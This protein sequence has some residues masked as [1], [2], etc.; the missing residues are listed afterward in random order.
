MKKVILF[1]PFWQ[2]EGHVGNNR[3]NRFLKWLIEENYHVIIICAGSVDNQQKMNW[4]ELITIR[5][6]MNLFNQT[7]SGK[8]EKVVRKPNKW[9]R[10]I[11]YWLFN[12]D[13]S[14]VW[15][16]V[17]AK[18][19]FTQKASIGGEFI[20]S[21]SP[22]E[23]AHI[24][25][26]IISQQ[27]NI[28]H[29]VDM[30]DGWLDEPLKPILRSS[31]LRRWREGKLE[32][33][34]LQDA[35]N[36]QVTSDIWKKLLCQRIPEVCPKVS[37]LTNGYPS[38]DYIKTNQRKLDSELVLIHA[39]RFSG[40]D[41]RRTPNLLL[42]PLFHTLSKQSAQGMI[43]LIGQLSKEEI[44]IIDPFRKKFLKIGWRIEHTGKIPRQ[45]LLALLPAA[46]G[47]LL[48]S[49]SYAAI[50]SK[51]FEYIPTERPIFVVT[52]RDSATWKVCEE[53]P[54]AMLV[55]MQ[56][57]TLLREREFCFSEVKSIIPDKYSNDMLKNKFMKL[58]K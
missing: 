2:Q 20:L 24:G 8:E 36:I 3:V 33:K 43:K 27:F 25:A 54:Q 56:D 48:L 19:A 11:A 45:E 38:Y 44:Q 40:S 5:D 32:R 16:K 39:G 18:H 7:A 14:V 58:L 12:P 4:G 52:E 31:A 22:P 55:G 42:D 30:R 26:W 57:K 17:A 35:E 29:I 46:D 28:P 21:S 9:R 6:S 37:V 34:I 49:A 41:I 15:A 13:P 53:L 50:P 47:L 23:S 10:R 51:L 1:I